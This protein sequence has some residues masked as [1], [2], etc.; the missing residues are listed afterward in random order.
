MSKAEAVSGLVSTALGL[1]VLAVCT[2]AFFL[3]VFD[4]E[5]FIASFNDR[6][7]HGSPLF[8]GFVVS[9]LAIIGI[10]GILLLRK[11]KR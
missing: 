2:L 4:P 7:I 8:V 5:A 6:I 3:F 11:E 9:D 1:V 10:V